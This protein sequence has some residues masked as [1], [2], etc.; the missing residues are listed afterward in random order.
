MKNKRNKL[1]NDT[2]EVESLGANQYRVGGEVVDLEGFTVMSDEDYAR[3]EELGL[4]TDD[5]ICPNMW[6]I[7]GE[8]YR[9]KAALEFAA[10]YSGFDV[11]QYIANHT[12][13]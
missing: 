8:D 1:N 11:E 4:D 9:F 6:D 5:M 10:N 13:E 12:E 2:Y 7:G 3:L